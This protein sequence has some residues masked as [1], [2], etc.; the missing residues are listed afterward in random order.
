MDTA[1]GVLGFSQCSPCINL[2]EPL[3]HPW[4]DT[5][6]TLLFNLETGRIPQLVRGRAGP[7]LGLFDYSAIFVRE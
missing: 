3:K 2:L 4:D 1:L 5:G 6:R 7:G